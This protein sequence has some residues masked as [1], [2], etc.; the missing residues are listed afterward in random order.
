MRVVDGFGAE[1]I[2]LG[3]D[4]SERIDLEVMVEVHMDADASH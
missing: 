2:D 3:F 1:E 4:G